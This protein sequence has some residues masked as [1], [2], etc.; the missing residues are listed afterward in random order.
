MDWILVYI[1]PVSVEGGRNPV[2]IRRVAKENQVAAHKMVS[3]LVLSAVFD[4]F[5]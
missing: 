2:L 4:L 3:K 5:L 1:N